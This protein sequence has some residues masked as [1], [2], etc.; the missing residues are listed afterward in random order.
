MSINT[1]LRMIEA[2][3]VERVSIIILTALVVVV[4]VFDMRERRIPNRL[5]FPAA[6]VGLAL[7]LTQGWSGLVFGLEGLAVGLALLCIPYLLGAMG[8][9]DVK[10]LAAIGSF[11]GPSE[12]VRVLLLTVLCYPVMAAIFVI[13]E[14]KMKLTWLRFRRVLANFLGFFVPGLKLYAMRLE[15]LDTPEIASVTTP[16]CVAMAAGTLMVLYTKILR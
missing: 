4:A 1:D 3:W 10:L 16:F 13:R 11:V 8:A 6:G 14:R 9:G 12:I 2:L 15:S 7:N 5:V